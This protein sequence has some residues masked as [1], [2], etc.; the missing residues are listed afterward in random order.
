[1]YDQWPLQDPHIRLAT[2]YTTNVLYSNK[3]TLIEWE[4]DTMKRERN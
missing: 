1:M 4:N 2:A 3:T